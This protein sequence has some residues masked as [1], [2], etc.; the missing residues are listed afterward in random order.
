MWSFYQLVTLSFVI[1]QHNFFKQNKPLINPET[2]VT[3][4][5]TMFKTVKIDI[6]L[7]E[8]DIPQTSRTRN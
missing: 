1:S 8:V 5:T 4:K 2:L 3:S 6:N 7:A